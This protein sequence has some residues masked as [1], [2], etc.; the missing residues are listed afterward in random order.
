MSGIAVIHNLDGRP[1]QSRVLNRMLDAIAHRAVDGRGTWI[2]GPTAMGQM[3]MWTTAEAVHE[4][5]PYC[6]GAGDEALCL[7]L[8]GRVDNRSELRRA[9]SA[10]GN[11]PR[12]DTDADLVLRAWQCW[13][14]RSPLRIIGDFAYAI[15]DG[16]QRRLFCVRDTCG[17]RPLFYYCDEH[18]LLCGSEPHQLLACPGVPCEPNAPVIAEY[19][20]ATLTSIE[21]TLFNH[22]QRLPPAHCLIADSG[23]VVIKRYYDLDPARVIRYGSD[24]QYA[25]HFLE[26]FKEAVRCR[27]RARAAVAAELSGGLDSS[28]VVATIGALQREGDCT[29]APLECFSLIYDEPECDERQYALEAAHASGVSCNFVE[30]TLTDYNQCLKQVRRYSDLPDY[31]NGAAFDGLREE[32]VRRGSRVVLTGLGGDQWLQGSD[33]YLCDLVSG[34]Q[35]RGLLRQLTCDRR[36]G[37]LDTPGDKLRVMLRWGLRP[38]LPKVTIRLLKR[39]LRRPLYLDAIDPGFAQEVGLAV[40]LDREPAGP[41]AMS[42]AQRTIYNCWASPWMIHTLEM[43]DR[44]NAWAG[45]EGRHPFYD[46]RVVEFTFAIPEEQR[47]RLD[48][49][50]FVLRQA[51][52]GLLPSRIRERRTKGRFGRV[53]VAIFNRMGGEMLFQTMAMESKGWIDAARMRQLCGERLKMRSG[54]LW[55]LWTTFAVDLWFREVFGSSLAE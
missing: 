6:L 38:M 24:E 52:K 11:E 13:G 14:E 44:S 5:Q 27:L 23:G 55:P 54:D 21:Q 4:R 8:D 40:R 19:M 28:S 7:V 25:E 35:W 37:P 32:L 47:A 26:V 9:L 10:N 18:I 34:F 39:L 46:R 42:Y 53:F 29:L 51:M 50:K 31:V 15:W 30:P 17:I 22:L 12:E 33:H 2:H 43:D 49:T 16:R 1:A 3:R 45:V 48:L 20:C 36:Y 41:R